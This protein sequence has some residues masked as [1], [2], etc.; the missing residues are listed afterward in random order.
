MA[1]P[2]FNPEWATSNTYSDGVTPNKVRPDVSLRQFGYDQTA[3]P[4]AQELNWQLNNLFQQIQEL[5]TL[6]SSAFQTP[7][8]E[9]K[10]IVGDARNPATIYGYGQWVPYANGRVVIGAGTS[11]DA[12]GLLQS[13]AAGST[14]GTSQNTLSTSQMP[15][16]S[17]QYRDSYMLE[18]SS[19]LASVPASN[20]QLVGLINGGAGN[21]DLDF[22]NN[23]LVFNNSN[24]QPVG[25][26]QPI[27]NLPPYIVCHIWLRIA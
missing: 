4:T 21:G 15:E 9:L 3:A 25:G 6:S 17:H 24:T 23:T 1:F 2:T 12:N 8:N 19:E 16:H 5:K 27:N 7:V 14:G 13:F 20:K 26:N 11:T 10:Y 22:D 18:K